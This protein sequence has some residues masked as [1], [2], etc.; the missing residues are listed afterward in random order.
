[1]SDIQRITL[2]SDLTNEFP[3]NANNSFKV[4]LPQR[5]TLRGDRWHASLLS[6]SVP[7][8]GQSNGV[9][10]TDPRTNVVT[11]SVT[12]LTRKYINRLYRR[13]SFLTTEY[14]VELEDILSRL[15]AC[16]GND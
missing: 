13:V 4:Q 1:M 14:S 12:Y 2:I 9:I 11:F 7:D 5:L 3:K 8:Q 15:A 16:F 10:A 6:M